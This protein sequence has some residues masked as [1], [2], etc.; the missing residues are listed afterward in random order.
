MIGKGLE[1]IL[2]TAHINFINQIAGGILSSLISLVIFSSIIWFLDQIKVIHP[3]T[4]KT[5]LSYPMLKQ[6]PEKSRA[7]F[8]K[9]KPF[10][11]EFWE[12]TRQAMDKVDPNI[13]PTHP[14]T[15]DELK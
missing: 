4:Q 5:S 10:F 14:P 3:E 12:K 7:V 13:Q 1:K 6:V 9:I 2:E 11:S 8:T 15:E